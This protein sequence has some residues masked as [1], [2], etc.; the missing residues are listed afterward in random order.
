MRCFCVSWGSQDF[1]QEPCINLCSWTPPQAQIPR[2]NFLNWEKQLGNQL[3]CSGWSWMSCADQEIPGWA[4]KPL[5]SLSVIIVNMTD[6]WLTVGI[7]SSYFWWSENLNRWPSRSGHSEGPHCVWICLG[8]VQPF[9][10]PFLFLKMCCFQ[11][12][13]PGR[14]PG[15][16]SSCCF[17]SEPQAA[18]VGWPSAACSRKRRAPR[19][20][21]SPWRSSAS[22]AASWAPQNTA[23]P[24]PS[25]WA[26]P[27]THMPPSLPELSGALS[28]GRRL[29]KLGQT[30]WPPP[31]NKLRSSQKTAPGATAQKDHVKGR[32]GKTDQPPPWSC[33]TTQRAW[34]ALLKVGQ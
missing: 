7:V 1:G 13:K 17:S 14:S 30:R 26:T 24:P 16:T 31:G 8:H 2:R 21:S 11:V 27:A 20:P 19:R 6:N 10:P 18:A 12:R 29:Y 22:S 9:L 3:L 4:E 25:R 28:S 23:W 15:L 33:V 5:R 34:C 32:L